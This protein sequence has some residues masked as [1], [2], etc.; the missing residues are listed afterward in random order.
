MA[1]WKK[2]ILSVFLIALALFI[3]G[4]VV[5]NAPQLLNTRLGQIVPHLTTIMLIT[6][7]Y[8]FDE[9]YMQLFALVVGFIKDSYY[10]GFLGIYMVGF[11]AM[12]YIIRQVQSFFNEQFIVYVLL[13]ILGIFLIENFAYFIYNML[14]I[15]QMD[16]ATFYIKRLGITLFV[17]SALTVIVTF[18]IDKLF[19]H[20]KATEFKL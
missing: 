10:V 8:Y 1:Q 9:T 4:S 16:W 15:T 6:L 5:L 7:S 14:S 18:L 20:L 2:V 13:G 11:F 17:N 12:I 3:D 19:L